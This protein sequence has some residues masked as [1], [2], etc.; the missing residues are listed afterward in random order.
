MTAARRLARGVEVSP[1]ISPVAAHWE[2]VVRIRERREQL[3]IKVEDIKSRLGFSRNYWSI[4]E[5]EH[6][7]IPEKTLRRVFDIL[8]LADEDR[9]QLLE[10]RETAAEPGWWSEHSKLFD[11]NVQRMLGLEHAAQRI[12]GYETI[13][14]PGLLQTADYARTIMRSDTTIRD[15]EVKQRVNVRLRRQQLLN[16]NPPL[17]LTVIISEAV[18]RQQ[19]GGIDV[20][21]EQLD[22]L[23]ELSERYV[24]NVEIRVLPFVTAESNLFGA[25]TLALLDFHSPRLPRIAW[26]ETVSAWG[27]ISDPEKIRDLDMAFD[28]TLKSTM[29][30]AETTKMVER[31]RKDL[32]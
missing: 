30:R 28:E 1:S 6:K 2:L 8:E 26:H 23:L 11:R 16:G 27:F 3:G 18:L 15:V 29:G 7:L 13:L 10:L 5:N 12:R 9:Q 20:H 4:I 24:N 17:Q 32:R 31:Y 14:V 19:I 25:G 21:R 22:H